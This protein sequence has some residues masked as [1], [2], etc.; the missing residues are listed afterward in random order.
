MINKQRNNFDKLSDEQL[1]QELAELRA[2]IILRLSRKKKKQHEVRIRAITKVIDTRKEV[3]NV[4]PIRPP[5]QVQVSTDSDEEQDIID[6]GEKLD[7][8]KKITIER[9][10]EEKYVVTQDYYGGI[11]TLNSS[12][13]EDAI[14]DA[15]LLGADTDEIERVINELREAS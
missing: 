3:E 6:I 2:K 7:L 12:S 5:E 1:E 9:V 10:G 4:V 8:D 14:D 13:L 11:I 15:R